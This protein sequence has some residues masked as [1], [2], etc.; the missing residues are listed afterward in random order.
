[1]WN[2]WEHKK[3]N[4]IKSEKYKDSAFID[5]YKVDDHYE[6]ICSVTDCI[7][8]HTIFVNGEE[9]EALKKYEEVK[10][11]LQNIIDSSLTGDDKLDLC[12]DFIDKW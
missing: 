9:A 7:M 4:A 6:I 1:M 3:G 10:N 12:S 11:D 2:N 8:F 5:I